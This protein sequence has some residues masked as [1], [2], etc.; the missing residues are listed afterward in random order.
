MQQWPITNVILL[1]LHLLP[2][3]CSWNSLCGEIA[4]VHLRSKYILTE[5]KRNWFRIQCM[6]ELITWNVKSI[7]LPV[8]SLQYNYLL[9]SF[10]LVPDIAQVQSYRLFQ[11]VTKPCRSCKSLHINNQMNTRCT[12][13][14]ASKVAFWKISLQLE[15]LGRILV[16]KICIHLLILLRH[17]SGRRFSSKYDYAC[18]HELTV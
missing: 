13:E 7:I 15:C 18:V 11:R 10:V 3:Y 16:R 2:Y 5:Y 12:V 9:N 6:K 14:Y 17:V 1:R 8:H 4:F